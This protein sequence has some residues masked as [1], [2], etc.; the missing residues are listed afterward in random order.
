MFLSSAVFE[1]VNL[2]D[3]VG[4]GH[5]ILLNF[6][7]NNRLVFSVRDGVDADRLSAGFRQL[8]DLIDNSHEPYPIKM[9]EG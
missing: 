2:M 7:N 6:D 4:Q 5:R 8:A 9:W 1:N 3:S